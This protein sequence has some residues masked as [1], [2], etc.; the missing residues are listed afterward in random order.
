MPASIEV[1]VSEADFSLDS[2]AAAMRDRQGAAVGGYATFV[3]LVREA[4]SP[5]TILHLEHY[6]GMTERSIAAIAKQA[7]QRWS[8][9]D[10]VVIHRVGALAAGAQIVFVGVASGHRPDAFAACEFVMDYLKTD[11][12]FWKREVSGGADRWIQSTDS[13]RARQQRW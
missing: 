2:E 1:R 7:S 3:G 11:A 13:D 8:I 5:D 4:A 9:L 6:P 12:V 10:L